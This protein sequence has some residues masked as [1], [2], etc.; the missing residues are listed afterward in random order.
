[1]AEIENLRNSKKQDA[2]QKSKDIYEIARIGL[3]SDGVLENSPFDIIVDLQDI[4]TVIFGEEIEYEGEQW[5]KDT[6]ELLEDFLEEDK[7]YLYDDE[8]S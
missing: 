4:D 5:E 3:Y 2:A 8:E 7:E 6:D 1:M